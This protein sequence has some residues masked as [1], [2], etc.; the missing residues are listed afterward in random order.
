M[1]TK[2]RYRI[3][4][5]LCLVACCYMT[6]VRLL[7]HHTPVVQGDIVCALDG[8]ILGLHHTHRHA[9]II[10]IVT[11]DDDCAICNFTVVKVQRPTAALHLVPTITWQSVVRSDV[12]S[13]T[14]ALFCLCL[15]RAPPTK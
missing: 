6:G 11:K 9:S 14:D 13:P 15:S 12:V 2:V 1:M 3:I 7:H 5:V 4:A 8:E 10:P